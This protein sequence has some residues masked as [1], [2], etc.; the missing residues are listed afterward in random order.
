[1]V[2]EFV[3]RV[4]TCV[5]EKRAVH[6]KLWDCTVLKDILAEQEEFHVKINNFIMAVLSSRVLQCCNQIGDTR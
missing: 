6:A 4:R 5:K 3:A 1:M 2:F